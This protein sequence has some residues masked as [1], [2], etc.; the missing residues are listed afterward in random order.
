MRTASAGGQKCS[1]SLAEQVLLII[2]ICEKMAKPLDQ[3]LIMLNSDASSSHESYNNEVDNV[4]HSSEP[5]YR[6]EEDTLIS[7]YSEEPFKSRSNLASNRKMYFELET[8]NEELRQALRQALEE[9]R[10]LVAD[11]KLLIETCEQTE[12]KRANLSEENHMLIREMD[13][14]LDEI[15][16]IQDKLEYQDQEHKSQYAALERDVKLTCEA[17]KLEQQRTVEQLRA[18]TR[19]LNSEKQ[20]L[21]EER[22]ELD[23]ML[24][25][26]RRGSSVSP[27]DASCMTEDNVRSLEAKCRALTRENQVLREEHT[28]IGEKLKQWESEQREA[29]KAIESC[30]RGE[31]K[32]QR[33]QW[34]EEREQLRNQLQKMQQQTSQLHQVAAE[35]R[36]SK[37][38]A[39]RRIKEL[40]KQLSDIQAQNNLPHVPNYTSKFGQRMNISFRGYNPNSTPIT[41]DTGSLNSAKLQRQFEKIQPTDPPQPSCGGSVASGKSKKSQGS[42]KTRDVLEKTS[43]GAAVERARRM[44]L[45][46]ILMRCSSS[47]QLIEKTNSTTINTDQQKA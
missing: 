35:E 1:W 2:P 43:R 46:R 7:D 11:T 31:L 24:Q 41:S 6:S 25:E 17:L 21:R 30:H 29:M 9:N 20:S 45:D 5:S 38:E 37:K 42:N 14:L 8:W 27:D 22:D 34:N 44:E 16:N 18:E 33:M 32:Q 10:E 23:R 47:P 39:R 26:F 3:A 36:A 28:N 15:E 19:L 4:S 40:E 13:N 12:Y